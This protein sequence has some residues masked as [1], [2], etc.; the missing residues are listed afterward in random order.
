MKKINEFITLLLIVQ[1]VSSCSSTINNKTS[2]TKTVKLNSCSAENYCFTGIYN[3]GNLYSFEILDDKKNK[4]NERFEMEDGN[5]VEVYYYEK[6]DTAAIS[7][8]TKD[9]SLK[10]KRS[11]YRNGNL[12]ETIMLKH[13]RLD[14]AYYQADGVTSR[15]HVRKNKDTTYIS[16]YD[17]IGVI[18]ENVIEYYSQAIETKSYDNGKEYIHLKFN[19]S[20]TDT[21]FY[22]PIKK[23]RTRKAS[24]IMEIVKTEMPEL[25]HIYNSHLLAKRFNSKIKLTMQIFPNGK[26]SYIYPQSFNPNAPLQF[27]LDIVDKIMTWDFGKIDEGNTVVTIP[28]SFTDD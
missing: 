4:I 12:K 25:R 2:S 27:T 10:Y 20:K 22:E 28:F 15:V 11:L 23:N 1:L 5:I 6:L 8:Y 9:N 24:E 3:N 21:L 14:T 17:S 19:E 26:V 7:L 16:K 18:S 13:G